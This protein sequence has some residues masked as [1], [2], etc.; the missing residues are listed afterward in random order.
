GL[1]LLALIVVIGAIVLTGRWIARHPERVRARW[2]RFLAMR[3]VAWVRTRFGRPLAFVGNRFRP[4]A[5]LGLE[6]TFGLVA[7]GLI[8][9]GF[10]VVTQHVIHHTT[11][12]VDRSAYRLF[13]QHRTSALT[14]AMKDVTFLGSGPVLVAVAVVVG[15]LWFSRKRTVR[16]LV[17]LL[18][19]WGGA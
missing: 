1:I 19:A 17:L 15:A 3:S 4:G 2:E 7:I 8:G 6:L 9:W 11:A 13:V 16:P 5:A 18:G 10:G 14:T 12:D